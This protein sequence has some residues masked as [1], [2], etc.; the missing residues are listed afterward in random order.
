MTIF[1]FFFY[2]IVYNN[3][4]YNIIN[5]K[6]NN[7]IYNIINKKGCKNSQNYF[8]FIKQN[9]KIISY[10]KKLISL[11]ERLSVHP[12]IDTHSFPVCNERLVWLL[13]FNG[14]RIFVGYLMLKPSL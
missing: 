4:I 1:L 10:T 14:I 12:R 5:K 9:K 6:N 2:F 11:T 3:I 8:A 13:C 7:I